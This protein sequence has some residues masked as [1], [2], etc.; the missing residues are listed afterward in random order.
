VVNFYFLN[1]FGYILSF[2]FIV[3]DIL[4]CNES[5]PI[6]SEVVRSNFAQLNIMYN[7]GFLNDICFFKIAILSY[8]LFGYMNACVIYYAVK[9]DLISL[10]FCLQIVALYRRVT[11]ISSITKISRINLFIYNRHG[12]LLLQLGLFVIQGSKYHCTLRRDG[13]THTINLISPFY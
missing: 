2:V 11:A 7:I 9:H 1:L 4:K 13:C 8:F 3:I 12:L 5:V 10:L 6:T